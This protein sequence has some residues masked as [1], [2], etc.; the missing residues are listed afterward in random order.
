MKKKGKR[1]GGGGGAE[2]MSLL[3]GLD[4]KLK[5]VTVTFS[6]FLSAQNLIRFS[7]IGVFLLI[8]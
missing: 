3:I 8:L 1:A 2:F 7:S 5:N 6:L 4:C